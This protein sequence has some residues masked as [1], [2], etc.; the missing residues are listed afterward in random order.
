M[1]FPT[2]AK[3]QLTSCIKENRSLQSYAEQL[4]EVAQREV[5]ALLKQFAEGNTNPGIGNKSLGSGIF[6]C[7]AE[8]ADECF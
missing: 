4:N 6:F 2:D 8:M 7:V 1:V 5:D 3:I